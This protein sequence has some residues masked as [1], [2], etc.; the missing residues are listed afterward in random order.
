MKNVAFQSFFGGKETRFRSEKAAIDVVAVA[1]ATH[2]VIVVASAATHVVVVAVTAVVV[3][4][5][6][7]A[8]K[9]STGF[10]SN[11]ILCYPEF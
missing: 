1:A 4:A 10:K 5:A 7:S 2:V 6:A 3:V 9:T 11:L 8:A